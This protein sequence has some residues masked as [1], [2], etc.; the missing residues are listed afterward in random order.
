MTEADD[1]GRFF[2]PF[3]DAIV[4]LQ[5]VFRR[6]ELR[7]YPTHSA[8]EKAEGVTF[9]YGARQ[10]DGTPRRGVVKPANHD[11]FACIDLGDP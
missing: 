8:C 5:N 7:A 2:V 9:E 10:W 11:R 1:A 4:V 3:G 6:F